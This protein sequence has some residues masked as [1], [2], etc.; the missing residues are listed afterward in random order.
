MRTERFDALRTRRDNLRKCAA[1]RMAGRGQ[2][3]DGF[4]A[5]RIGHINACAAVERNA[6]A[7]MSDM[8]DGE[9]FGHGI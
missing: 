6:V 7:E 9:A 4:F 2:H 1:V 8:I 5:E 3:I